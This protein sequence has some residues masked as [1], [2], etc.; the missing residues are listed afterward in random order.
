MARRRQGRQATPNEAKSCLHAA[1][2]SVKMGRDHFIEG[3]LR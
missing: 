2:F 3:S 1:K